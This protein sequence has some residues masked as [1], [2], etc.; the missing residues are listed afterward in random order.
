MA[1]GNQGSDFNQFLSTLVSASQA[2]ERLKVQKDALALQEMSTMSQSEY[3]DY[4]I[5]N[6]KADARRQDFELEAIALAPYPE[7]Q[8]DWLKNQPF[9]KKNPEYGAKIDATFKART[10][11]DDRINAAAAMPPGTR[12]EEYRKIRL[13]KNL[14]KAQRD[15]ID[16]R[17]VVTTEEAS[18]TLEEMKMQ[19]AYS[20]I[21][22][23]KAEFIAISDAGRAR[24]P[25]NVLEYIETEDEFQKRRQAALDRMFYFEGQA[26]EQERA[27]RGVYPGLSIP[28]DKKPLTDE[29]MYDNIED[30]PEIEVDEVL[31]D[32]GAPV[33]ESNVLPPEFTPPPA[34]AAATAATGAAAIP[35]PIIDES[36]AP[37][38]YTGQ[39]EQQKQ[40]VDF[41]Y[42]LLKDGKI[43]KK[44]FWE[45]MQKRGVNS[46]SIDVGMMYKVKGKVSKKELSVLDETNISHSLGRIEKINEMKYT[47][48]EKQKRIDKIKEQILA[49]DP[50]YKFK[51]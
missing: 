40:D 8:K 48:E 42:E 18:L 5:E 30:I 34:G 19:P 28:F 45:A 2:N 44:K 41:Y 46:K 43:S 14:N 25:K 9:I 37:S 51:N 38:V 13:N 33:I 47:Q 35:T 32:L 26:R 15:Y 20:D 49:I 6:S 16:K 3:R 17:L 39:D 22:A 4:L 21:L 12:L 10:E 11:L 50:N 7:L 27:G 23:A 29:P 1:N 24:D 31:G 36:K